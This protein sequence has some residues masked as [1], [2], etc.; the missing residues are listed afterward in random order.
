MYRHQTLIVHVST[1]L[2]VIVTL[3]VM[4]SINNGSNP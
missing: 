2:L 4:I 1:L 3:A